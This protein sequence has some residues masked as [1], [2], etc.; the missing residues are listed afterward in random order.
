MAPPTGTGGSPAPIDRQILEYLRDR[1]ETT[2]QVADAT[3]TDAER[4]LALHVRL[5]DSYYPDDVKSAILLVRWYTND[6]CKIHYREVHYDH[7]WECRWDR[8]PS[9]HNTRDHFHPPP[10]APTPGDDADWPADYRQMLTVVL[11]EIEDRIAE[12]W[13]T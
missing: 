7:E 8:H 5:A 9:P 13:S 10:D 6:D 1:L 11:N 4:H 3:I 12:I 2:A